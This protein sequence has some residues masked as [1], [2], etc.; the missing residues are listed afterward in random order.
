VTYPSGQGNDI[1]LHPEICSQPTVHLVFTTISPNH[2]TP[3][4]ILL[5]L[6]ALG[7]LTGCSRAQQATPATRLHSCV[8]DEGPRDALCGTLSVYE[9]RQ[10]RSGRKIGL[11][12][13]VLPA[14][15]AGSADPL[16]F[17]AG[18]PGQ[19][20]AKLGYGARILQVDILGSDLHIDHS[21]L[22]VSVPH[23]LH[24]RGQADSGTHHIGGKG[25]STMPISA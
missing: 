3:R 11:N 23:K 10:T 2:F 1:L 16:F 15:G 14:V 9:N 13:V 19:G 5:G 21:G 24:E 25:M 20:A 6:L 12:I 7:L 8:T 17:L 4:R 18:G 22:N